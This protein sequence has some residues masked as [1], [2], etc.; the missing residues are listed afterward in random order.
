MASAIHSF[1]KIC[2]AKC[3]EENVQIIIIQGIA[4]KTCS[5]QYNKTI[6]K[7][8]KLKHRNLTSQILPVYFTTLRDKAVS[9]IWQN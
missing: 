7:K 4:M 6:V 9:V 8:I 3:E 2:V 5:V 1:G